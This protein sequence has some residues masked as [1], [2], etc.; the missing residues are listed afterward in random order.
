VA[1]ALIGFVSAAIAA[2]LAEGRL[3]QLYRAVLLIGI[4]A[5]LLATFYAIWRLWEEWI[6]WTELTLFVVLYVLTAL[7][8]T[9]GY[10]RLITHESFQTGPV[11]KAVLIVLGAMNVQGQV[12][13]WAAYHRKHHGHA[14]REGDPHSP[15]E[16]LLHS[17]VGWLFR[18]SPAERERY[19]KRLLA[20]PVVVFVDRTSVVWA[21]LGLVIPYAIAGWTGLLWGGL[22]RIAFTNH[23][24]FAVNSICHLY[25]SRAF[26]TKDDSRN[27]L[28]VG[29]LG[30][31]EGWHNNH[32]AFPRM[33]FHGLSWRQPDLS[34]LVIRGLEAVG[35]AWDV[36]R[37]PQA[38]LGRR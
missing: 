5:P 6:G 25:G 31:G 15:R 3:P 35:L 18:A 9:V 17:H 2:K 32:H 1:Y 10:H 36:K 38:A 11:V 14:D 30:F 27:N 4:V 16:G 12:I 34:G 19:C 26:E 37:P 13:N 7:G 28:V 24:T 29:L 20:D 23:V 21:T 22:V 33:A 8:T